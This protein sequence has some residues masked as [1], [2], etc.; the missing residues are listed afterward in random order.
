MNDLFFTII[1]T[2]LPELL[3]TGVELLSKEDFTQKV[4]EKQ[5]MLSE[6]KL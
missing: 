5:Q 6:K 4:K 2:A 1:T 3:K